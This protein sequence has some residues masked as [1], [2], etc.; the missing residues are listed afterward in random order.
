MFGWVYRGQFNKI[1]TFMG[2]WA[3]DNDA[4]NQACLPLHYCSSHGDARNWDLP[5]AFII[6]INKNNSNW[7][8]SMMFIKKF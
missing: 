3:D 5:D 7:S 6:V 1:S 2:F 4:S 8:A